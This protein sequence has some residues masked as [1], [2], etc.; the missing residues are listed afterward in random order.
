MSVWRGPFPFGRAKLPLSRT[1]AG[2]LDRAFRLEPRPFGRAK[3]L[4]SRTPAGSLDRAF[5]LEPRAFGRAKLLLSRTPAGSL[6]RAFRLEPRPFGRAKLPLSRIIRLWPT[7]LLSS[8]AGK[9]GRRLVTTHGSAEASPSRVW[10]VRLGRSLAHPRWGCAARQEPRPPEMGLCGSSGA[11][12]SRDGA[13]SARPE[14]RPPECGLCGSAEASPS[15]V[16]VVRLGGSLAL[17]SGVVSA[18]REPRPPEIGVVRLAFGCLCN[19]F[20]SR[21]SWLKDVFQPRT[22]FGLE[23]EPAKCNRYNQHGFR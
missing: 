8:P 21:L 10:V 20:F 4:L 3:L 5:R 22:T 23:P 18:R 12:P 16:W 11:S 19:S 7:D 15:R 6:D 1:P 9:R 14:P 13:V 2:S 17:P